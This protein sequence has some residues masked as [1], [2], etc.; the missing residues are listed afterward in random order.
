[1]ITS[2]Q[3]H[4]INVVSTSKFYVE[5]T[6]ILVDTKNNFVF[7]L[8]SLRNCNLY[9]DVG[10]VTV[11]QRWN[12]VNL[13]TLNQCWDLT[14]K[15]RWFWVHTKKFLLLLYYDAQGIIIFIFTPKWYL[16]FNVETTSFY[17]RQINVK[18]LRWGNVDFG[19]ALKTAL[20]FYVMILEGL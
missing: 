4:L 3:R 18:I 11:F 8:W 5:T 1:M 7:M 14:L 9:I 19:L 10:K 20:F 16:S 17:Q 2:K 6:L 12:N 15:Q 13:S